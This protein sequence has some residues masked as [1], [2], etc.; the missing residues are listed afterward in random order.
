M[1]SSVMNSVNSNTCPA[2]KTE[3]SM[4]VASS[5]VRV[6]SWSPRERALWARTMVSELISRT[7]EL[8]EVKGMS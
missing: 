2:R 4:A 5:Q 3:P 1:F 7:K 6:A 8:T